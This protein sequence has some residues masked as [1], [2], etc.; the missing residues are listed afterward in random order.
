MISIS[1]SLR[2]PQGSLGDADGIDIDNLL[3]PL[4]EDH[5]VNQTGR[6]EHFNGP[7]H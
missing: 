2:E 4:R 6:L 3:P 1:I 7:V 5:R